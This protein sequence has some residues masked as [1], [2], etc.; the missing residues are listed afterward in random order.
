MKK[1]CVSKDCNA[2]GECIFQTD[3]LIEDAAGYAVPV[4]DGYIK[5]ENLEKAQAVV[6][7]CPAHALSIVEQADIVLDADKMGAA[8]EKKLKAIDIPSVSSSELRFDEDDYQVSAGYADGEYDYKYSS[9]DKAVSAGA[10]RFRQVFWSRRSDYVL[11]YLSQYKSKVLRPY[12]DFSN[13]DKTYYA[14]F[15]KK[16]EEVLKAAKAELSAASEN[17]SVL[18]VDFTE[19]RPEKSKDFQTSFACS[20]DY[21]GD[22]SYVKEF[23]DDFERDS[24]N[25]LS[26]Y[27]DEI[28]AEGRE[29]YAGHGWLGDK[30]K[31]IYRFK[32]VNETGKRLVHHIGSKLSVCGVSEGY[33]LRCIDDIADDQVESAIKQYREIVSKAIDRKVAIYREAVQKCAK[34]VK[35]DANRKRT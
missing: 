10:Q 2:C 16:I 33:H 9:W 8:L 17:D 18:S 23:L 14:Q 19:F 27:E 35:A 11:A 7:A 5:A 32:D 25:R 26:S 24:Y 34:R 12:Y 22:A 6:S 20:M 28:C 4:A 13:P 30:Y 3:L 29:E 21:I 31:T 1:F 15:S